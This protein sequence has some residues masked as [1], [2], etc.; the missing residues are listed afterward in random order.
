MLYL[1]KKKK[2]R[3]RDMEGPSDRERKG[4]E[5]GERKEEKSFT[6]GTTLMCWGYNNETFLL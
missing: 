6:G 3:G 2:R 5:R 4:K 1:L